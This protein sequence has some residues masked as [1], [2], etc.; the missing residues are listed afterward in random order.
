MI[1]RPRPKEKVKIS[2]RLPTLSK[3]RTQPKLPLT[4]VCSSVQTPSLSKR[5]NYLNLVKF[6]TS[7]D[8]TPITSQLNLARHPK[9]TVQCASNS[10]F[11]P[12]PR[13]PDS[14]FSTRFKNLAL[15]PGMPSMS[16]I[17]SMPAISGQSAPTPKVTWHSMT[18]AGVQSG[19]KKV[20]QDSMALIQ[21]KSPLNLL[22]FAVFDGHGPNGEQ[23]S[24]Y[25]SSSLSHK[26]QSFLSSYRPSQPDL[27]SFL[28]S[29]LKNTISSLS[30]DLSKCSSID[31]IFS[32][33]TGVIVLVHEHFCICG[34]VG[35]SRAVLGNHLNSTWTLYPLSKD[36]K[37]D[38]LEEK[39][40]IESMGGVVE[41][42]KGK[43]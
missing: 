18:Q 39:M 25:L 22:V 10:N 13:A 3:V 23:V 8:S 12:I 24:S 4:Q 38:D 40:R 36:H 29:C 9:K 21:L 26:L 14:A 28:K 5:S 43:N 27:K 19:V 42:V 33:S 11:F 7:S 31:S 20:N 16:S 2:I 15:M 37:P 35:D 6:P 34:N 41:Q 17:S 30:Q 32:G 1:S